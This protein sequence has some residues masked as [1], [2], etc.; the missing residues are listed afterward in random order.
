LERWKDYSTG[1]WCQIERASEGHLNGYV[2]I[3]E[4]HPLFGRDWLSEEVRALEVE[5]RNV[6]T[7]Y[8]PGD[9]PPSY[10][11][12]FA[13]NGMYEMS[14]VDKVLGMSTIQGSRYITWEEVKEDVLSLARQ[15]REHES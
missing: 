11:L 5:R 4:G 14:P 9:E 10:W 7:V 8:H 1:Y 15:I 6:I 2:K 3:D 12:G 13:C